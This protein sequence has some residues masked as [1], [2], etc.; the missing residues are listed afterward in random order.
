M[1][2]AA[3]APHQDKAEGPGKSPKVGFSVIPAEA[4]IQLIW[5]SLDSRLR[6]SEVL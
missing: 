5:V 3:R 1:I 4:G 6:R 2:A